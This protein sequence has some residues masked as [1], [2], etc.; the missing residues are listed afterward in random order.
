MVSLCTGL[1]HPLIQ[2]ECFLWA[3]VFSKK[4]IESFIFLRYE[5]MVYPF[6]SHCV[7][8]IVKGGYLI[9]LVAKKRT[10]QKQKKSPKL[11][12]KVH[13]LNSYIYL[14]WILYSTLPFKFSLSY[15]KGPLNSQS[16]GIAGSTSNPALSAILMLRIFSEC[17][18]FTNGMLE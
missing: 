7:N 10:S 18:R 13:W 8:V 15:F 3:S 16:S 14:R 2:G 1:S 4:L 9:L 5:G 11:S 17:N 12:S 6:S